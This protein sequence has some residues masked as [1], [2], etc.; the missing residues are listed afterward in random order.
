MVF[1]FSNKLPT[2]AKCSQW[3]NFPSAFAIR[4][5]SEKM[6]D[7]TPPRLMSQYC[8]VKAKKP[9]D[10]QNNASLFLTS[11]VNISSKL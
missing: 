6:R 4:S 7:G 11:L 9:D 8:T 10:R 5:R 3:K 2:K 1:T